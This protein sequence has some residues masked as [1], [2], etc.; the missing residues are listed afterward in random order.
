MK[1]LILSAAA[2]FVFSFANAQ[3][4]STF[5]FGEGN[6]IVEGNLGF[7]STNDKNT[8]IKTSS[9]TFNPKAG[10]FITDDVAIGIELGIGSAREEASGAETK[11]SNFGVGAFARYYF[12][13][14]GERFKTYGEF[15]LGFDTYKEEMGGLEA[16]A[17]GFGAGLGLGMNYFIT[18][19]FAINFALSDI[20]SY[21]SYK[22]DGGEA[23]SEFNGNINVFDNFFTTAQF[24]LTFK[25]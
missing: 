5:G 19:N 9:F 2:V 18:E 22:P 3:E 20:L 15:G 6:I 13:E 12:L 7:N 17:S 21:S 4:T 10:Y 11:Q 16:K 25:F 14:L 24:G 8:D 1:K 23:I